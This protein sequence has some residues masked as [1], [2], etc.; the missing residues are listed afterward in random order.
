[1]SSFERNAEFDRWQEISSHPVRRGDQPSEIIPG[2]FL[3]GH[4][5]RFT[6]KG[7]CMSHPSRYLLTEYNVRLIL[8]CC[9]NPAAASFCTECL[10]DGTVVT[11]PGIN[12]FYDALSASSF[13]NKV[14]KMNIP[15]VDDES[16]DLHAFFPSSSALLDFAH[17]E[18]S[19]GVLVHCQMGVSRSAAIVAAAATCQNGGRI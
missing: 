14:G 1:M 12:E 8:C 2:L 5:S 15:A 3:S 17:R 11:Y 19:F 16:F 18:R 13:N 4:P 10:D 9:A 6:K 7:I